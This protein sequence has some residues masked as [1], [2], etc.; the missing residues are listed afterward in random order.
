MSQNEEMGALWTKTS[1]K[2]DKFL[3]GT[4]R[5]GDTAV[6]IVIFK[7]GYKEKDNQPDWRI[8]KSKPRE[9]QEGFSSDPLA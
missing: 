4:I 5:V 7:N 9:T 1:A 6:Q 8:Y 3:S 2:G